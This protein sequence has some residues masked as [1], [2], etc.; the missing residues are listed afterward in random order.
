MS[1]NVMKNRTR[2]LLIAGVLFFICI[3]IVNGLGISTSETDFGGGG[4][5]IAYSVYRTLSGSYV[6][7]GVILEDNLD[8]FWAQKDSQG[9]INFKTYDGN[10]IDE[11]HSVIDMNWPGE[12][13][14]LILGTTSSKGSGGKDVWLIKIS[15]Q[16]DVIWDK[17]YGGIKD[18]EGWDMVI[19]NE[20]GKHYAI[21]V[22]STKSYGS[23]GKDVWLMKVNLD[24]K[25]TLIW[26]KCFGD[27]ISDEVGYSIGKTNDNG[28]IIAGSSLNLN[29][30]YETFSTASRIPQESIYL[31][32]TDSNGDIGWSV[33]GAYRVWTK[34]Y[35]NPNLWNGL[36]YR[37]YDV[38]VTSD[39]NYVV[40]GQI[41][42]SGYRRSL[43][44]V[45][46]GDTGDTAAY[47]A[48]FN[49]RGGLITENMFFSN[50]YG[51]ARS[52]LPVAGEEPGYILVGGG[53]SGDGD[54]D[55]FIIKTD[56][57]CSKI[58][59]NLIDSRHYRGTD[60]E[61]YSVALQDQWDYYVAG[62]AQHRPS[63]VVVSDRGP[64]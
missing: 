5:G 49:S 21:I 44:P 57:S 59:A 32:K 17:T 60:N 2:S 16:G 15:P 50:G 58:W 34:K 1:S 64:T 26:N 36:S 46:L 56:L 9:N 20:F 37:A 40:V 63:L 13:G 53:K 42:E 48:K 25:G 11:G 31:I 41:V 62:S 4:T 8:V 22:G 28:Y 6:T 51:I 29:P 27:A 35:P 14:K 61:A 18:D 38:C 55:I 33:T 12:G 43:S 7:T 30:T 45:F 52:I 39:N 23:G 3:T 24:D 54:K 19:K 47:I 10:N